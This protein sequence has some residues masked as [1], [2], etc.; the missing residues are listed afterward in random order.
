MQAIGEVFEPSLFNLKEVFH[1]VQ[2]E[3][4]KSFLKMMIYLKI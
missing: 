1:G 3:V 4:K 2:T